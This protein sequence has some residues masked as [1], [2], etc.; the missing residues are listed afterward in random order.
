MQ[1]RRGRVPVGGLVVL[2]HRYL[3]AGT[4]YIEEVQ[5]IRVGRSN[6]GCEK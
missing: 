4:P 1:R 2:L 3:E 6:T 5:F